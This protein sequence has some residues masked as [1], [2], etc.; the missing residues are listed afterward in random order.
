[1]I[2]SAWDGRSGP[3]RRPDR[4]PHEASGRALLPRS[5]AARAERGP[6][7][8]LAVRADRCRALLRASPNHG[9]HHVLLK[10]Q[11]WPCTRMPAGRPCSSTGKP[12]GRRLEEW[13]RRPSPRGIPPRPGRDGTS[14][15]RV[16]ALHHRH[17]GRTLADTSAWRAGTSTLTQR[18]LPP[19]RKGG[20][21]VDPI[22]PVRCPARR[23][24]PPKRVDPEG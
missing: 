22:R 8:L 7:P 21:C 24:E 5:R 9:L 19:E 18:G 14:T 20:G 11:A 16:Q 10:S 23:P 3:S 17:V 15:Q 12:R 1:M 4:R 2:R 13:V 6:S